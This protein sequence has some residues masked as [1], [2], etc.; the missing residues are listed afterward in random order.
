MSSNIFPTLPGLAW[1]VSIAPT[2]STCVKQAVSGREMRASFMAY[3]LW[4]FSLS[5]EFLRDGKSGIE[6]DTMLGFFLMLKGQFDSFLYSAPSDNAVTAMAFGIGDGVQT[7]F[8]LNRNCGA[9]GFGFV[10]P[11]QNVNGAPSIYKAGTLQ[12][13]GAQYNINSTGMVTFVTPPGA[14]QTLTWTGS[15]YYR[16]RFLQDA[17]EFSTFMQDFWELKKMEFIGAPGNRV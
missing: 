16:C 8:Q 13:S 2:F 4:K 15:F 7:Q 9:G 1:N 6:L 14:G 3:P 10:E 12:A 11:V 17:A 5:Y